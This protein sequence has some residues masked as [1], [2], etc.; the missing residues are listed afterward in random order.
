MAFI[1]TNYGEI[2]VEK[3]V[4]V[5]MLPEQPATSAAEKKENGPGER[6]LTTQQLIMLFESILDISL[7]ATYTNQSELAELLSQ[8]SGYKK[9]SIRVKI[10]NGIDYEKPQARKDAELLASLLDKIKPDIALKLRNGA[11]E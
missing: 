5:D 6:R 3:Q 9:D 2:K 1:N 10:A 8:V 11:R 7:D 4:N